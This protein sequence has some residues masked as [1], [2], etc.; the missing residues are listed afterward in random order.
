MFSLF[1]FAYWLSNILVFGHLE[2]HCWA[3]FD[4]VAFNFSTFL[5]RLSSSW[6]FSNLPRVSVCSL[7]FCFNLNCRLHSLFFSF[8]LFILNS[9]SWSM[10]RSCFKSKM[11]ASTFCWAQ[12]ANCIFYISKQNTCSSCMSA[13]LSAAWMLG[14]KPEYPPNFGYV[15]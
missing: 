7:F 4:K 3:T 2:L 10:L 14:S 1:T 8:L 5:F 13:L 6:A 11:K 12:V 9:F 15:Q